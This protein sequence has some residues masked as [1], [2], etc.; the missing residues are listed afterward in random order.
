MEL[1]AFCG[2]MKHMR[3]KM[4][5]YS[6]QILTDDAPSDQDVTQGKVQDGKQDHKVLTAA[7]GQI[8]IMYQI[9]I[10]CILPTGKIGSLSSLLVKLLTGVETQKKTRDHSLFRNEG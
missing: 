8:N 7:E 2:T 9:P 6:S 5:F 1:K 10:L 3:Y 4:I